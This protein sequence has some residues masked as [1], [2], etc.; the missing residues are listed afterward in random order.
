[1]NGGSAAKKISAELSGRYAGTTPGVTCPS[2]VAVHA[3]QTFACHV[4]IDGQSLTITGTITA[5]NGDFTLAPSAAIIPVAQTAMALEQSIS[6]EAHVPVIVAC[7]SRTV[8]VVAAGQ[9]FMCTA[10]LR[11][12]KPRP[13]TVTV[14]N[15]EGDT[16]Y[17]LGPPAR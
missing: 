4:V 5:S 8:A 11:G 2:G 9:T 3:G 14:R 12:E 1:M 16:S 17:T 15:V 10:T 13:V 6:K 7:G